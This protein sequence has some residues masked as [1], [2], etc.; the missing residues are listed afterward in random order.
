ML[1]CPK[2]STD[3]LLSAVFCRG[4]GERLNLDEIKPDNF[5]ELG[6]KNKDPNAKKNLVGGIIIGAIVLILVV[7]T[8]FPGCGKL[9]TNEDAQKAAGI[10]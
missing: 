2:C 7:G 6:D 9:S 5:S 1:R 4:C 8:F 3:N 10:K